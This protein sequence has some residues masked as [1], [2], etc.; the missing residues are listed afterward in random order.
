MIL[1]DLSVGAEADSYNKYQ[2]KIPLGFWQEEKKW[3]HFEIHHS[4]VFSV[5]RPAL[6]RI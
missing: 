4:T 3:N 6:R 1:C 5:T 2:T